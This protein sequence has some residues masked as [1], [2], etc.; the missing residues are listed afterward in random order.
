MMCIDEQWLA[1]QQRR[2][3]YAIGTRAL[4]L[5]RSGYRF[6]AGRIDDQWVI[7]CTA[8][9]GSLET[10]ARADLYD[11]WANLLQRLI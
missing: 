8:P 4:L 9:D 2:Q 1:T 3:R 7:S 6:S 10:I 11:A 5:Y